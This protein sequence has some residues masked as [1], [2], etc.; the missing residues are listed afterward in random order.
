MLYKVCWVNASLNQPKNISKYCLILSYEFN[1]RAFLMSSM[2]RSFCPN[3]SFSSV[4]V[5]SSCKSGLSILLPSS[6]LRI[7]LSSLTNGWNSSLDTAKYSFTIPSKKEYELLSDS[8]T[9][10]LGLEP[11][12]LLSPLPELCL[13]LILWGL[14]KGKTSLTYS[15]NSSGSKQTASF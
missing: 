8:L 1:P 4:M 9:R 13:L 14:A 3:F 2:V 7:L 5:N 10:W 6:S 12:P 11:L 15:L